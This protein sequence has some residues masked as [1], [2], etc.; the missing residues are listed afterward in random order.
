[1]SD[2]LWPRGLQH[3]RLPC[4]SPTPRAYS[5]SCPSWWWRH[6]TISSSVIPS[7]SCLQS[8]PASGSF[9]ISRFFASG[10]KSIGVS[11]S[12]SVL[13][14]NVQ[15]W[16]P[17]GLILEVIPFCALA[18]DSHGYST[19]MS[20]IRKPGAHKPKYQTTAPSLHTCRVAF[21][22]SPCL[23]TFDNIATQPFVWKEAEPQHEALQMSSF[24]ATRRLSKAINPL[25]QQDSV[26]CVNHEARRSQ[27]ESSPQMV[28][29]NP[30]SDSSTPT[31]KWAKIFTV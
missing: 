18:E 6:P 21:L 31:N 30:F 4:P 24:S 27:G 3:A 29:P 16:F 2:S 26:K 8:F 19:E 10:D 17:L 5:N 22:H 12:A 9:P 28:S 20:I 11:A 7:S 23:H 15:D 1:M 14:M 25:S 13:P